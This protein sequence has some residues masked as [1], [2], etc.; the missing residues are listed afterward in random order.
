MAGMD[1]KPARS[2]RG[3]SVFWMILGL[4]AGTILLVAVL[5]ALTEREVAVESN[6]ASEEV[7]VPPTGAGTLPDGTADQA[8]E[9]LDDTGE[10]QSII[11]EGANTEIDEGVQGVGD[12]PGPGANDEVGGNIAED[13]PDEVADPPAEQL[14]GSGA[15]IAPEANNDGEPVEGETTESDGADAT[16]DATGGQDTGGETEA[17]ASDS[18]TDGTGGDGE[19]EATGGEAGQD[20][21]SDETAPAEGEQGEAPAAEGTQDDAN[22]GDATD[23]A[24]A[25]SEDEPEMA[26]R[27]SEP[28]VIDG[29]EAQGLTADGE[30]VPT[31]REG[32]SDTTLEPVIDPNDGSPGDPDG[33]AAPFVPTPS[34]PEGRDEET[35]ATE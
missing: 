1:M 29:I 13:A 35:P 22:A 6:P 26:I 2:D 5:L 23:G 3:I 8:Q 28:R 7:D 19:D 18:S 9:G 15:E 33:G 4:G 21:T 17:P 24:S 11:E 16:E 30:P 20:A 25:G 32:T 14:E 34:G 10:E 27:F 12:A 31:D